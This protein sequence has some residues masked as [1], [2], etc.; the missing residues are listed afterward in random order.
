MS[1]PSRLQTSVEDAT[2]NT[3][4]TAIAKKQT[5]EAEAKAQT[6]AHAQAQA[7]RNAQAQAA[8][9]AQAHA[10]AQA[11]SQ[12]AEQAA[13]QAIVATAASIAATQH[14]REIREEVQYAMRT[15][16]RH[17]LGLTSE[18]EKREREEVWNAFQALVRRLEDRRGHRGETRGEEQEPRPSPPPAAEE[19]YRCDF[20][21]CNGLCTYLKD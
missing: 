19:Y 4:N 3:I 21:H 12:L 9:A 2:T 20:D 6:A 1:S 16:R 11:Q 10:Y 18:G 8:I 15:M 13:E 17:A 14:A 5:R 7:A